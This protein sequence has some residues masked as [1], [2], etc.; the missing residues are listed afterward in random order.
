MSDKSKQITV[1]VIAAVLVVVIAIFG[2]YIYKLKHNDIDIN[3]PSQQKTPVPTEYAEQTP[4]PTETITDPIENTPEITEMV[5]SSEIPTEIPIDVFVPTEPISFEEFEQLTTEE[6]EE[7]LYFWDDSISYNEAIGIE[8]ELLTHVTDIRYGVGVESSMERDGYTYMLIGMT[9]GHLA[10]LFSEQHTAYVLC[11]SFSINDFVSG[12]SYDLNTKSL[13]RRVD[14]SFTNIDELDPLP[15]Q[16]VI[17]RFGNISNIT[18]YRRLKDVSK[19]PLEAYTKFI[20]NFSN[21]FVYHY[22]SIIETFLEIDVLD[23][24]NGN[25]IAYTKQLY[26]DPV[27]CV[28]FDNGETWHTTTMTIDDYANIIHGVANVIEV[29]RYS[30]EDKFAT[31]QPSFGPHNEEP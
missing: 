8:L 21:N 22:N 9:T 2:Y 20:D 17:A 29:E 28:S 24:M 15:A 3:D 5:S 31:P 30:Y 26:R 14:F 1:V 11:S 27:I 23:L 7:Y 19:E 18:A 10:R 12:Q 25:I 6:Q 13:W 16:D 4:T